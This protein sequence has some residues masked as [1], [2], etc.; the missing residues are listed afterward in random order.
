MSNILDYEAYQRSGKAKKTSTSTPDPVAILHWLR[1]Q[2]I[3]KAP[4]YLHIHAGR[5]EIGWQAKEHIALLDGEVDTDWVA[6]LKHIGDQAAAA[7]S[8]AFGYVGFDAWDSQQGI[9]PDHSSTFPLVQFFIPEHRLCIHDGMVEYFGPDNDL[10]DI[11]LQAPPFP[12][13]A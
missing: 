10:L 7:N 9:A 13:S 6:A 1:Q 11:A 2:G 4:Y 3:I 12:A 5:A 8:K